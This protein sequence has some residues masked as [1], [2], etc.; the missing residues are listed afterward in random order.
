MSSEYSYRPLDE[1]VLLML[2]H[3][4][5]ATGIQPDSTPGSVLR[6]LFEAAGFVIED[7]TYQFDSGLDAKIPEAVFTAFGFVPLAAQKASV[8]LT[9]SRASALPTPL[10]IP[11]AFEV[12]RADGVAYQTSETATILAG[13]ISVSVNAVAVEA[14]ASGNTGAGTITVPRQSLP[15]LLSVTNSVAA[16]GGQDA[17]P[18]AD[19]VARF[20]L[21]IQQNQRATAASISAAGLTAVANGV[22]PK[23]V[24]VLDQVTKGALPAG[25]IEVWVDD[26]FGTAPQGMLDAV[27][28][29]VELQRAAG[30]VASVQAV[31]PIVV[32]VQ[33]SL[34]TGAASPDLASVNAAA[35][36]YFQDLLVGQKVSW[37][38]LVTSLTNASN[39]WEVTLTLPAADVSIQQTERGVLGTLTGGTA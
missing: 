18:L 4:W 17:E 33:Y 28:T 25:V 30:V 23:E 36:Q 24:V 14:G 29:V 6:T 38:N 16:V 21:F 1:S 26:G 2:T 39:G 31:T 34:P 35:S 37:E 32:N 20:A 19:Q 3:F 12:A 15:G 9:F 5:N 10:V 8:S 27:S 13:S 11:A 22:S 7:V